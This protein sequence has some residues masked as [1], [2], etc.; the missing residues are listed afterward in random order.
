[1]KRIQILGV[2]FAL[3]STSFSALSA[4]QVLR[5]ARIVSTLIS[6]ENGLFGG[7]MAKVD[8]NIVNE[9]GLNCKNE[10]VTFDCTANF[11]TAAESAR[12]LN[13][14]QMADALDLKVN[15][16]LDDSQ[17]HNGYCLA[18]RVQFN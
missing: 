4:E 11:I 10:W 5:N 9:T 16:R 8:L 6:A 17:L 12:L 18:K 3:V 1:M 15:L 7:C 2:F 14:A 13:A